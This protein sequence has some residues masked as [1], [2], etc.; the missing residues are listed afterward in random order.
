MTTTISLQIFLLVDVFIIGA[1][2]TTALRHA[3]AHIKD[4]KH[5]PGDVRPATI[6]ISAATKERLLK[7]SQDRFQ[8]ML[9]DSIKR[10]QHD[11][12]DTSEQ[13]NNLTKRLATEV[14]SSELDHYRG[15]LAK[16]H[17]QTVKN[18]EGIKK[19]IDEHR[20]DIKAK[21]VQE[22]EAE[23]QELI[24]RIDTKLA[25]AVGSFLDETLQ[26][27]IDLGAQGAYL[28]AMLEENKA[29]FVDEVTNEA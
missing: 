4:R 7:A 1:L 11:L 5:R 19:E 24:K 14:V 8:T 10:L 3:H 26:H 29:N 17:D 20:A 9:D 22:L 28:I 18:L 12:Q 27:N 21:V 23:K 16:L 13:I 25:D 6:D 2:T 15:D